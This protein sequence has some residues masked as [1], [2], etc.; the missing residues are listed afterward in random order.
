MPGNGILQAIEL[1]QVQ[2]GGKDLLPE[3]GHIVP[4]SHQHGLDE[5]AREAI[6]AIDDFSALF[7]DGPQTQHHILDGALVD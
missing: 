7:P 3:D 4:G 6:A 1:D 5:A 2:D